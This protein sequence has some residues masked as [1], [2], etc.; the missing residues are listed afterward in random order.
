[1]RL[2]AYFLK[3]LKENSA[4]GGLPSQQLLH[5]AG[6]VRKAG[7][8]GLFAWMPL[9]TRVL[10]KIEQIIDSEM[11]KAG[12]LKVNFPVIQT[13]EPWYKSGRLKANDS[14]YGPEMLRLRDRND[15]ELL[16]SPTAEELFTVITSEMSLSHR[17]L[18]LNLYQ[19]EKKFRDELRPRFGTLRSR[20]FTMKDGY[21]FD[22]S[23][24]CSYTTYHKMFAA[25]QRI[26]DR[27]GV[28]AIPL[29]APRGPVGGSL[30]HEFVIPT[31]NGESNILFDARLKDPA[32][33][34]DA[35]IYRDKESLKDHFHKVSSYRGITAE[36]LENGCPLPQD[37]ISTSGIEVGHIFHLGTRYSDSLKAGF[38]NN[39][40][41]RE[42]V[43]MG[44]YGIGVSRL[45]AAIV[46]ASHD[47]DGI[48]WS[49]TVAPFQAVVINAA[50]KDA[51]STDLADEI[52]A[53]LKAQGIDALYDDR[54]VNTGAK[55]SEMDLIG[56]PIQ[57]RIG[58]REAENRQV[59]VKYRDTCETF[60]IPVADMTFAVHKKL[61][62]AP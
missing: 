19:V 39:K 62:L 16:V 6:M 48:I 40:G 29:E 33:V 10:A 38:I 41:Q 1:M 3:T 61:N 52:Y 12:A 17:D 7:A 54:A 11:E 49:P 13:A 23:E 50:V 57:I 35:D 18:P 45:P 56:I 4:E 55:Y 34:P 42:S 36:M 31:L 27:I 47:Q 32:L 60:E 59:Q 24:E 8:A 37:L 9:G 43:N 53:M 25:Y 30:S 14:S 28:H 21:S 44:C 26:F 58:R 22:S 5:R 2:S 20:E 46:E 51:A 15:S